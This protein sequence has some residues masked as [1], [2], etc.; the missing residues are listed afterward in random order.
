MTFDEYVAEREARD[1]AFRKACE[2][3]RPMYEFREAIV[4]ARINAGLSQR[5]LAE[6]MGTTQSAIARLESATHLP[7][8]DT[9]RR[10]AEALGVDFVITPQDGLTV[11]PHK[12]A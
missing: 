3:L 12:A 7:G 11:R 1:P 6:R 8:L 5:Q 4:M 2:Q 10:L 9:L